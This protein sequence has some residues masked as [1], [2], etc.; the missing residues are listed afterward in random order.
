M[1][2]MKFG[3]AVSS[4]SITMSVGKKRVTWCSLVVTIMMVCGVVFGGVATAQPVIPGLPGGPPIVL[5]TIPELLDQIVPKPE[6]TVPSEIPPVA[7]LSPEDQLD[8]DLTAIQGARLAMMPPDVRDSFF[9]DYPVNLADF[10]NGQII[11]SRDITMTAA[12]FVGAPVERVVQ[13]KFR[14][15]DAS[16]QPS[17]GTASL[18][19]P[20][21]PWSGD[22]ARPV[23]VNNLPIN[24]LGR[25]CT[26]GYTMA[27][28]LSLKT[29]VTDYIPPVTA[30]A[31][32]KGYAVLIPDHEGPRMAY[33]VT[34]VAGHV[35]LDSVRA[36]R[37]LLPDQFGESKVA[38]Q[39]YSGGA[40]AT[41]GA[42]KLINSYAPELGGEDPVIVGAAVGGTPIDMAVLTQS[43]NGTVNAA[44]G[45]EVAAGMGV[46]REY[47][48][49]VP[50]LGNTALQAGPIL[51]GECIVS[52]ALLGL[53]PVDLQVLTTLDDPFRSDLARRIYADNKMEG[54]AYGTPLFVYN[55]NEEFWIPRVMA[56]DLFAE[57][58]ALGVPSVLRLPFGEH[59]IA[60]FTGLPDL[61]VWLDQRL[62][63]IPAPSEC[64]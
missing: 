3:S 39:G 44:K 32:N 63:G 6:F 42:A 49:I 33:A 30:W 37:N 9:N 24:G 25:D 8:S 45:V 36:M 52:M 35:I 5:P 18:V 60:A 58:C 38:M 19:I 12:P 10:A 54:V 50:E 31:A 27:N 57:Q 61:A 41:N 43:L 64:W 26:P 1:R 47:P 23:L 22:G 59:A 21:I 7:E 13:V 14:S 4:Q 46:S 2:T 17:F 53:A 28:G 11:E 29:G 16:N 15:N 56:Q 48:E 40:I 20:A 55:G 51:R 62:G 34:K